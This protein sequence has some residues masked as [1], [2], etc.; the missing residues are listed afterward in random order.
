MFL[1][2]LSLFWLSPSRIEFCEHDNSIACVSMEN[3]IICDGEK[4]CIKKLL[5]SVFV[6]AEKKT[7][8]NKT[9]LRRCCLSQGL[10]FR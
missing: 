10:H 8:S 3:S 2:V 1:I 6:L 5:P 7:V 9:L 4:R